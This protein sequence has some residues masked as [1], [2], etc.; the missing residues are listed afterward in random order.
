MKCVVGAVVTFQSFQCLLKKLSQVSTI[1]S[2]NHE[3]LHVTGGT[4]FDWSK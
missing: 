3:M 1:S 4:V 2:L